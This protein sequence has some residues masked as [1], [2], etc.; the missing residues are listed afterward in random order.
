MTPRQIK[1]SSKAGLTLIEMTLGVTLMVIVSG[2]LVMVMESLE[3]MTSVNET[4]A[5]LQTMADDALFDMVADLRR[6]SN[7]E[8]GGVA[9]PYV[10]DGGEA[11]AAFADHSHAAAG[12]EAADGDADAG[13]DR[14]VVF[15]LPA[16]VD[17]DGRP[18]VDGNG[19]L[20]WDMREVSF[21]VRTGEDGVNRLER[22]IDGANPITIGRYVERLVVDTSESSGFVIPLD[23]VRIR[24]FFR[25]LDRDG[26]LLR[27]SNE[28]VVALRN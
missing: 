15:L 26:K 18:D 17:S 28:A 2:T 10:F 20:E 22:R 21:T 7:L 23:S 12:G 24:L 9:F 19:N 4:Q 16:D 8:F 13:P 25:R 14:E 5:N 3:S 11:D 6:S 1:R 27:Y